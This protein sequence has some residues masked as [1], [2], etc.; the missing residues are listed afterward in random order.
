M[1]FARLA[2][3]AGMGARSHPCCH[4]RESRF[5]T[6]KRGSVPGMPSHRRNE[7]RK[8]PGHFGESRKARRQ[9]SWRFGM[10]GLPHFHQGISAPGQIA[11]VECATCH[12]DEEKAFGTS[13]HAMLGETACASCHGNVHELT[14]TEK[15][16]PA[17]CEECHADEVKQFADSIHGQA[18]KR[19][20]PDAPTCESCHGSIHGVKP[21]DDADSAVSA[22]RL[23]DTCAKCHSDAGFLSRHEIPIAH[24]VDS[25]K[26]S[27]HGQA[28][29]AGDTKAA[30]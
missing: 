6:E 3:R 21:A 5:S 23:P 22:K 26:Q 19:G 1:E 9:R 25:Y 27:V 16:A 2:N 20:D 12:S 10:H 29:A 4:Q 11:K 17:K 24:P 18:A 15:L 30:K 13:V 28:V 14:S 8:R 7:V